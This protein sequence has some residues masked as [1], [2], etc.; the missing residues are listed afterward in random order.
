MEKIEALGFK[1]Y[2]GLSPSINFFKPSPDIALNV[3]D[4]SSELN[5]LLSDCSDI[6]HILKSLSE[7]L[8]PGTNRENPINIYIHET[9][10]ENLARDLLLLTIISETQLSFRERM[11]LFTDLY[12]NTM[13]RSKT[14]QYLDDISVEVSR[15]I[16]EHRKCKS[17]LMDLIDFDSLKF[18]ERDEIEDIVNCWRL[19]VPFDIESLRDQRL[20]AYFKTRYDH[21]KNL[22]DWDYNFH[23]KKFTK[24]VDKDKYLKFRMT[25]VAFETRLADSKVSNR[26]MS[27]YVEGKKKKSGDSCLVRGFWGDIINSPYIPMG[28]EVENE[29]DRKK[30]D[31][32][33][34]F[35]RPYNAT[36]IVEYHVEGYTTKLET[37]EEYVAPF[38]IIKEI[39]NYRE[40]KKKDRENKVEE[41]KEEDEGQE[42]DN[43]QEET[44]EESKQD[45]EEE[46]K[47]VSRD[48]QKERVLLEG[49]KRLNVK[50]HLLTGKIDTLYV[51]SKFKDLFNIAVL[52]MRCSDRINKDFNQLLANDCYI[53]IENGHN[54]VIFDEKN[55]VDF[56]KKLK[57]QTWEANWKELDDRYAHHCSFQY[58]GDD[59]EIPEYREIPDY[60][61]PI[62]EKTDAS[63]DDGKSDA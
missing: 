27:S 22:I 9:D 61:R 16:T 39:E 35:Q 4:D 23:I 43:P 7:S 58:L 3:N 18:K 50:I 21:R 53:M 10:P 62:D 49:F 48:D 2:Y 60:V 19:S 59:A 30:F 1:S 6:R 44:K 12:G 25:G 8:H 26:S 45:A 20:R 24:F 54:L 57:E 11:E 5:I 36:D 42:E 52:S 63:T 14:A 17:V 46:A 55:K 29:E 41:I 15:L 56:V 51:K 47:E 40:K 34:N 32:E 38:E 37:L 13:I 31:K 33:Y 28:I